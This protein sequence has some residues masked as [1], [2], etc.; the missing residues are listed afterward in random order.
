[1]AKKDLARDSV[2]KAP[3]APDL[4]P[5]TRTALARKLAAANQDLNALYETEHQWRLD[6]L[7]ANEEISRDTVDLEIEI[8]RLQ[9]EEVQLKGRFGEL[10]KQRDKLT[11]ETK[12]LGRQCEV[13]QRER[14]ELQSR[15]DSLSESVKDLGGETE[16]LARDVAKLKADVERLEALRKDYLAQIAK[17]RSQ[18]AKLVEE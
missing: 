16:T 2:A 18:K 1:M 17:F 8:R 12:E 5:V 15:R 6:I 9:Q 10:E 13:M 11:D 4:K 14:D 3:V 7:K